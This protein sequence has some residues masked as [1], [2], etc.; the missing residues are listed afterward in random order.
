MDKT[1]FASKFISR[2]QRIDTP[3][4][5]S[6]LTQILKEKDFQRAV[7]DSL[8]EGILVVDRTGTI[9]FANEASRGLLGLGSQKVLGRSA[10]QVL[11][12]KA[13][14][15]IADEFD[16]NRQPI[17]QRE[18]RVRTP[19][20]RIYSV[21]ILPIEDESGG[22]AHGLWIVG[23]LTET[24][25]RAAERHQVESIQSLATL[26]AGIAHEIKNPLNS[27]NI[28]A[29]LIAR[30][31]GEFAAAS[32]GDPAL[33][34]L[35][36]ST[37]V[38]LEEIAR[39]TRIVDQFT[40]AARPAKLSPRPADINSIIETVAELI[41]P[42]C[43]ARHI[44]LAVDP[45]P[46]LPKIQADSEQ[47][48]QAILNIAKNAME[49][50]DKPEGVISLRTAMKGDHLLIEVEDNGC[51]IP[52]EDR[53]R[54]F[55]PYHTTKFNGTGLGL[56][57][58]FRIVSAHGGII[59]LDSEVGRGTTLRIALPVDERPVLLLEGAVGPLAGQAPSGGGN[60]SEGV[61]NP[62]E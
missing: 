22:V 34:R 5:E 52:D 19:D 47:L 51:G 18:V 12:A 3:R 42:E 9:V 4:I 10:G 59:G 45:D 55:E 53:L 1:S 41:A 49:A 60:E 16:A 43:Q 11:R 27:M 28:H 30:A 38:L 57:V 14:K 50:I 56:M 37:G 29:Q 32:A 25:R 46:L 33:E 39:L 31:A 26:T 36:R 35:Q 23:D 8:L 20:P 40:K 21:S 2:I 58:V 17:V 48:Q 6:F 44:A 13:L 15:A 24:H 7:F 61:E 62:L 54:V